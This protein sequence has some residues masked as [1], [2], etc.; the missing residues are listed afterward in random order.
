MGEIILLEE[1]INLESFQKVQDD[2]A[3]ATD[4]A[5]VMVDYKGKTIT[6]H[7]NCTA[8]CQRMRSM[9]EYSALCEKCDSRGG[10]ESVRTKGTYIY[11]CHKGIVD[12]AVPIIVD[13]QYL[14]SIMGG[15]ILLKDENNIEL[16]EIVR[17]DK[18]FKEL[19]IDI[20]EKI[21]IEYNNLPSI[22][23]EKIKSISQM[24]LHICN[25]IVEEAVLKN[26][27]K[28]IKTKERKINNTDKD[29]NGIEE[30]V[31]ISK[32]NTVNLI[33][34]QEES[35]IIKAI[36]YIEDN[37]SKHITLETIS[38]IC[39][40]SPS[41]FSKVF[42]REMG[43]TFVE[44]LN[45]KKISKAKSMLINT[46]EPINNIAF[47]LGFEDCGYFIKRFKKLEGITPKKFRDLHYLKDSS[48]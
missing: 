16:E 43:I 4:V 35:I 39:N 17:I 47:E 21:E 11:K 28:K 25:Y 34:N 6:K 10:L 19:P 3:K 29:I 8:F 42:K 1:I 14:G 33:I 41:Y 37:I 44:Y 23:Y 24:M 12:F 5:I 15:Q 45:I 22:S 26:K 31:D 46:K 9:R 40:L 20:K 2:I 27:L 18:N 13:N 48:I 36:E 32:D 38:S 7:S 30:K